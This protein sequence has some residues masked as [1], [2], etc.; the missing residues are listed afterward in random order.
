TEA[1]R[2][3]DAARQQQRRRQGQ[4]GWSLKRT[5][6]NMVA[7]FSEQF[8]M[9]KSER[10]KLSPAFGEWAHS[11]ERTGG[12]GRYAYTP[13]ATHWFAYWKP[14]QFQN[15]QLEPRLRHTAGDELGRVNVKIGDVI[16]VVSVLKGR[17]HTLGR[18]RM[19][20]PL[21]TRAQ[22]RKRLR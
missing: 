10:L 20:C 1:R 7:W 4:Q 2:V 18:I 17:L 8:T 13:A 21:I 22:A 12:P 15:P 5:T 11:F 16:W 6:I 9:A 3:I 19:T 14:R